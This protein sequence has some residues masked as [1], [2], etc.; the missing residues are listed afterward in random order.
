MIN[1]CDKWLNYPSFFRTYF[2]FPYV[3]ALRNVKICLRKHVRISIYWFLT[4]YKL[5]HF[6]FLSFSCSFQ[7]L[8]VI[9]IFVRRCF[10][11]LYY[12]CNHF[13]SALKTITSCLST[14]VFN[15]T[16]YNS[17]LWETDSRAAVQDV[18]RVSFIFCSLWI[19]ITPL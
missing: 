2:K 8:S 9:C 5:F 19:I 7:S 15:L 13:S 1:V 12:K 6:A 11:L 14:K 16:P 10:L 18:P 17:L 3:C 4:F